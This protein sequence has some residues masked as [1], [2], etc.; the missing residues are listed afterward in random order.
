VL[1][2]DEMA[3]KYLSQ[4]AE[5][6]LGLAMQSTAD[7][8]ENG[9]GVRK[10]MLLCRDWLWHATL[11]KSARALDALDTKTT[12]PLEHHGSSGMMDQA[13]YQLSYGQTMQLCGPNIGS[14]FWVLCRPLMTKNYIVSAFAAATPTLTVGSAPHPGTTGPVTIT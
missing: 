11:I 6:G 2:T 9:T 13:Q 8:Y 10:S 3:F 12:A 14:L 1:T 4:A 5:A 7:C